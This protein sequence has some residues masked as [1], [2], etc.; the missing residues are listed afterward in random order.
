MEFCNFCLFNWLIC[1][2]SIT[3]TFTHKVRF[4]SAAP[5]R[6]RLLLLATLSRPLLFCSPIG[7]VLCYL[8]VFPPFTVVGGAHGCVQW[9]TLLTVQTMMAAASAVE[10][11][12]GPGSS[13]S[14]SCRSA[15]VDYSVLV[16]VGAL[17]TAG[18]LERVLLQIDVGK[19][20][21]FSRHQN[22]AAATMHRTGSQP[23]P[24]Q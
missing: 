15:A 2:F 10:L 9:R 5:K 21:K 7:R 22:R 18:L 16:V 19:F 17:R 6:A 1:L 8:M 20:R 4:S 3:R 14:S 11:G 12:G 23:G 13:P 24:S